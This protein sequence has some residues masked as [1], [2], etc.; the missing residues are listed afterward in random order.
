MSLLAVERAPPE[1]GPGLDEKHRLVFGVQEVGPQLVRKEP[2]SPSCTC[3]ATS[4][5]N[6]DAGCPISHHLE[7]DTSV[8]V[9]VVIRATPVGLGLSGAQ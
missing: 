5:Q 9:L 1:H 6:A 2:A 7:G 3:H 8:T 4:V